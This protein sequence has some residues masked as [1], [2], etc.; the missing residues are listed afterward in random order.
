[1]TINSNSSSPF[2]YHCRLKRL[3]QFVY[4]HLSEQIT[5]ADAASVAALERHYFCSYFK[6]VVGLT[7]FSWLS[8]LRVERAATLLVEADYS[9]AEVSYMAGFGNVRSCERAFRR[10]LRVSP[11]EFRKSHTV[12]SVDQS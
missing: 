11:I 10:H 2:D 6:R 1:M 12:A 8:R 7:F 3:R 9:I 5:L 4:D